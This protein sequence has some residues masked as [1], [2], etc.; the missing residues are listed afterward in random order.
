MTRIAGLAVGLAALTACESG[1]WVTLDVVVP[2]DVASLYSAEAPG[3]LETDVWQPIA[4]VCGGDGFTAHLD[5]DGGF[6]CR[7]DDPTVTVRAWIVPIPADWDA[8]AFCALDAAESGISWPVD[9]GAAP[10]PVE[11]LPAPGAGDPQGSTEAKW[12]WTPIC[13]GDLDA[14]I[15]LRAP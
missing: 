13:G 15:T 14:E 6:G 7:P 1:T 12:E 8:D 10:F 4:P 9:T 5:A 2:D 11:E 3:I